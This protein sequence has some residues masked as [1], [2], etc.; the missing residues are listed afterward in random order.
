MLV[1]TRALS[2]PMGKD[3]QPPF[4]PANDQLKNEFVQFRN[5]A[6]SAV[7]LQDVA[8]FHYTFT[9]GCQNTGEDRLMTFQNALLAGHSVR[10]HTG[11]G[12]EWLEGTIHHIYAGRSNFVWNNSCS[13][14]AVLRNAQGSLLDWATYDRNPP[15]GVILDRVPG[16]NRLAVTVPAFVGR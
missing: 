10:V 2:N 4:G 1:V 9:A 13:D 6:N 5:V 7:S 12:V 15:E 11:T 3:R 14:T 16:T 8:L